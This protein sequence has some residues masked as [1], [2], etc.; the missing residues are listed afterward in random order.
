MVMIQFL[1]DQL[2]PAMQAGINQVLPAFTIPSM[3]V[4]SSPRR[5]TLKIFGSKARAGNGSMA[6]TTTINNSPLKKF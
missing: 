4:G 6:T 1:K 2:T 5:I 3:L